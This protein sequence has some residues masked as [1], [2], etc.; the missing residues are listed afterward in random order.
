[1]LPGPSPRPG[2]TPRRVE[3]AFSSS[4]IRGVQLRDAKGAAQVATRQIEK[5]AG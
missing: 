2:K 3:S 1:V 4:R 5:M